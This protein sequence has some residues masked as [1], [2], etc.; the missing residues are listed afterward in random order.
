MTRI[1]IVPPAVLTNRHLVAEYTELPRLA[2]YLTKTLDKKLAV[3]IKKQI[4]TSYV[5]GKGHVYFWYDKI[6]YVMARFE[7]LAAEM[8]SRG[9]KLDSASYQR[10]YQRFRRLLNHKKLS[11]DFFVTYHPSD[12]EIKINATRIA[13]R[14]NEKPHSYPDQNRFFVWFEK[15]GK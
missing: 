9:M 7:Q 15:N 10:N 1:N 14:I 2:P 11:A 13:T 4:M 5:L 8:I 3:D 6:P 12:A